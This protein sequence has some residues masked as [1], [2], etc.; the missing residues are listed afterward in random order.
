MTSTEFVVTPFVSNTRLYLHK[1]YC[2]FLGSRE[3]NNSIDF[4]SIISTF[5]FGNYGN[6]LVKN[7]K[8]FL[9]FN[10]KSFI[11]FASEVCNKSDL[12]ICNTTSATQ[13]TK[14]A[15]I[16]I[17]LSHILLLKLLLF[18]LSFNIIIYYFIIFL[19]IILFLFYLFIFLI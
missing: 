16:T 18:I 2:A 15:E 6:K 1:L 7:F 5:I 4:V 3:V 10:N 17:T 8:L 14:S 9:T 13:A 19:F 12:Y 11:D